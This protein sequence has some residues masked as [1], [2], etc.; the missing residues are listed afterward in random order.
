MVAAERIRRSYIQ[1]DRI[2]LP[3]EEDESTCGDDR[4]EQAGCQPEHPDRNG[5]SICLFGFLRAV[6][7][8]G[9]VRF[10]ISGVLPKGLPA[11][12]ARGQYSIR[13]SNAGRS[14]TILAVLFGSAFAFN[15][16]VWF[17]SCHSIF[18]DGGRSPPPNACGHRPEE[19]GP[20]PGPARSAS[21]SRLEADL[22]G[23]AQNTWPVRCVRRY[24]PPPRPFPTGGPRLPNPLDGAEGWKGVGW[25]ARNP[26]PGVPSQSRARKGGQHHPISPDPRTAWPARPRPV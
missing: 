22:V 11:R 1:E 26:L 20:G 3:L 16:R 19:Q 13:K 17:W 24:S 15:L 9:H 4:Q 10:R 25:S 8:M 5:S 6:I 2:L 23:G 14:R 18:P 7:C 12:M 21:T